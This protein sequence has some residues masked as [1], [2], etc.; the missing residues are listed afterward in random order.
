L[1]EN[2]NLTTELFAKEQGAESMMKILGYR[3]DRKKAEPLIV[4]DENI[5]FQKE[6]ED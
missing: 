1:D 6:K 2:G 5:N 4:Q 3:S